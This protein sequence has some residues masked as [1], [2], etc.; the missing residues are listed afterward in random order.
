[1]NPADSG[2]EEQVRIWVD[3]EASMTLAGCV[4][5]FHKNQT[6]I[7][8]LEAIFEYLCKKFETLCN[9]RKSIHVFLNPSLVINC[10]FIE[11]HLLIAS[12]LRV[13][14][15]PPE[16]RYKRLML[17][18][19][20]FEALA[21]YAEARH[22]EKNI[23]SIVELNSDDLTKLLKAL[24]IQD[25]PG[26]S[27][28]LLIPF[29]YGLM[30]MGIFIIWEQDSQGRGIRHSHDEALR[31]W[32]AS[33]YTF[34]QTFLTREYEIFSET[35]LPSFYSARWAKAAILFADIRN[36]TP[37]TEVLRNVYGQSEHPNTRVFGEIMDEHCREMARIIQEKGRG[38]IDKFLG[39]GIMAIFGE[40]EPNPTKAVCRAVAAAT[41]MVKCFAELK[42]GFLKKAFGGGYD[43]EYNESVEIELGVGIDYGTVLFEYLGDEQHKE[44][45]AIGDHVNFAQRLESEAARVNERADNAN[46]PILISPTAERC[47]RPWLK[48]THKVIVH[49]KGKGRL[50]RVYGIFP[51]DFHRSLYEHAEKYNDWI[52]SWDGVE[53]G[54]PQ[55]G[56]E[57]DLV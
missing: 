4:K 2:E 51:D 46:P 56:I 25:D 9:Y 49:P 24:R 48:T 10:S 54:P 21:E 31:G 37:L 19:D 45:T 18:N 22:A 52:T 50:Y 33:Y 44:Y 43:T 41:Q 11:A 7:S 55:I 23:P 12:N 42:S 14:S 6:F 40:H 32:V 13:A 15:D 53:G 27:T 20:E 39:D 28:G 1:M 17:S 26:L 47:I 30:N 35:Y 57:S 3:Y 38:R 8:N 29:H 34:L 16:P 5:R 36:F